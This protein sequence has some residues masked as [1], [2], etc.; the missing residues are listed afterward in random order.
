MLPLPCMTVLSHS[1]RLESPA[2]FAAAAYNAALAAMH[3]KDAIAAAV[4]FRA[5]GSFHE[6]LP[7]PTPQCMATH[8]VRLSDLIAAF[9]CD[10]QPL[11]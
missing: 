10:L 6:A 7:T 11:G 8:M 4:M 2:W 5:S 1:C 9:P 3:A